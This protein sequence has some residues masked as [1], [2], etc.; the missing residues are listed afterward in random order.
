VESRR[1]LLPFIV[2]NLL[3][4]G[5][6]A[7]LMHLALV[8]FGWPEAGALALA[9]MAMFVWNFVINKFFIFK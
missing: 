4:V 1:V 8:F 7:G 9:T 3:A 5:L 2:T 6:N